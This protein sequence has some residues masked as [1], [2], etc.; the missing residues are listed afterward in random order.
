MVLVWGV[1][2]ASLL[3]SV[4]CAAMCGA[5]ACMASPLR[6]NGANAPPVDHPDPSVSSGG[7][8][9]TRFAQAAYHLGRLTSYVLLGLIAG[10]LG[11]RLD[12]AGDLVG[13]SHLAAIVAGSLMIA[14]ALGTIAAHVG[15]RVPITLAPEWARRAIGGALVAA[16]ERSHV[17][18]AYL[19]GLATTL[20]PCGWLYTFVVVAAGTGSALIG[21]NVMFVF[22]I[23]TVPM[24][25]T[26][27]AG[28]ARIFGPLARRMPIVTAM[29][30]LTFGVLS[31]VGKLRMPTAHAHSTS[32]IMPSVDV[33][34]R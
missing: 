17:Q 13:L 5:F 7:P 27:V 26:I 3:G 15:V 9:S 23:G 11:A 20:L 4:H 12:R 10:A 31:I 6:R 30:V 19:I 16:R 28:S 14:W 24:L 32:M 29:M 21:A 25:A 33:V 22:W 2:V 8:P 18:R 34:R 1:F